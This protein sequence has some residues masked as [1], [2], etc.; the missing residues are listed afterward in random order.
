MI[1]DPQAEHRRIAHK[2]LRE[3]Q[4]ARSRDLKLN[5]YAD[6]R[7][8]LHDLAADPG[9]TVNRY[10]DLAYRDRRQELLEDITRFLIRHLRIPDRG[11]TVLRLNRR[12]IARGVGRSPRLGRI[13]CGEP[14]PAPTAPRRT[15]APNRSCHA[16]GRGHHTVHALTKSPKKE[17]WL[18]DLASMS[19][20]LRSECERT[21]LNDECR[22]RAQV[23]TPRQ[24]PLLA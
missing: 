23:R 24:F 5:F 12:A 18:F 14:P 21:H 15:D 3:G 4:M 9:E 22:V 11:D 1:A 17:E 19:R 8:K 16:P 7:C 20:I 13:E 6:D 10:D 2:M